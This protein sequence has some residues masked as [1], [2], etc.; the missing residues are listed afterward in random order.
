MQVRSLAR[1]SGL[2]IQHCHSLGHRCGSDPVLLWAVGEGKSSF[3][4]NSHRWKFRVILRELSSRASLSTAAWTHLKVICWEQWIVNWRPALGPGWVRMQ[5]MKCTKVACRYTQLRNPGLHQTLR[6][7][8][9]T[10]LSS[11]LLLLPRTELLR[12]QSRPI[13]F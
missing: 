9:F 11:D 2:R 13:Y 5:T 4:A 12:R 10:A 3:F 1:L 8:N 6:R 7:L